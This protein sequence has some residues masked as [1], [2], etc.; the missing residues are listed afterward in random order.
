M[1][2]T[3][4][5]PRLNYNVPQALV[6]DI[7]NICSQQGIEPNYWLRKVIEKAVVESR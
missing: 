5:P 4:K 1:T 7:L 3:T 2:T 6:G